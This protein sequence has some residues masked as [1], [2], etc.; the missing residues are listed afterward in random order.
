M[1]R[2]QLLLHSFTHALVEKGQSAL[3]GEIRFGE[4][5]PDICRLTLEGIQR[6]I[7]PD[8]IRIALSD[9]AGAT[10]EDYA[11]R[12]YRVISTA[13]ASQPDDILGHLR[14]LLSGWPAAIRQV[15][16]RP[17]DPSGVTP[18]DGLSI[19][20]PDDLLMFMPAGLPR[21]YPGKAG[22]ED[23]QLTQFRGF[24]ECSEVW[25]GASESQV[26]HSPAALKYI[27][28]AEAAKQVLEQQDIFHKVFELND[29]TGIVPLRNVYFG[30]HPP[31]LESGYVY[32]YDLS[33]LIH[34]WAWRLHTPKPDAALR[35]VK[36]LAEIVGKAHKKGIVH[37]DLKP[38]NVLLHPTEGGKFTMWITDYG[39]GQMAGTRSVELGRG[40]TPRAEQHR[41]ALR[42]AYTPLYASPQLTKKEPP[43]PRDDV[44]ALGIIWFQLLRR[45]PHVGGP[46]GLDWADEFYS[47]GM[48]ENQARLLTQCIATRPEKRPADANELVDQ[49]NQVI[50]TGSK[51]HVSLGLSR[52]GSKSG[53]ISGPMSGSLLTGAGTVKVTKSLGVSEPAKQE[54]TAPRILTNSI[55]VTFSLIRPGKFLRGSPENEPG[56]R[57]HEGPQHEVAI[58]RPFYIATF[59]ITQA[60]YEKIKGRNPAHFNKSHGGGANHP[61]EN[62]SWNEAHAYCERLNLLPDEEL[63][64]RIYRLPTEAEWE[65][66][67][68]A[69]TDTAYG[70]GDKLT[71][72]DAHFAPAG[73]KGSK[74]APVGLLHPN[75]WGLYDMHGNV[76]EW[77]QDWYDEYYYQD[78]PR[79]DPPGPKHGTV[80]IARG[81][82]WVMS[83]TDCRSAARRPHAPDSPS[84][85]IGFRV[86]LNVP[87]GLKLPE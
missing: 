81:G 42:G 29:T 3:R 75:A 4:I 8:D 47:A 65:Y 1:P 40:G 19:R 63:N 15:L 6:E 18:P 24:G 27:T 80:K 26:E 20:K 45:E 56:H 76:Q 43:D 79:I 34:E 82:C 87:T 66:A 78:C 71:I 13:A 50:G 70:C 14:I 48:T 21:H 57:E 33:G 31:C 41:L 85:G 37:R 10:S 86:V 23:W 12:L 69:G 2:A 60:Q 58:T 73:S 64:G 5:L 38:S 74:T 53:P 51:E 61:V 59:P 84:N 9:L 17:S 16:R 52:S 77:V 25:V 30:D 68:R 7:K 83:A 49:L 46:A 32:G 36:R 22:F 54:P 72:R 39:W 11:D 28:D 55:G 67:C 44:H 62:V 35:I